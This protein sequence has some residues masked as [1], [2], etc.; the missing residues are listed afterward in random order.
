[1]MFRKN[2]QG[3]TLTEDVV[4]RNPLLGVRIQHLPDKVLGALRDARPWVAGE[5]DLP[6]QDGI[7]D[8]VLRFC[9]V[10]VTIVEAMRPRSW[11]ICLLTLME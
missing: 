7:E 8:A 3:K 6:S 2:K 5:V 10:G 4:C 11:T 1:M 9:I